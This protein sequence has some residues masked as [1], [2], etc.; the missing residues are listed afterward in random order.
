MK[1]ETKIV[2]WAIGFLAV[3]IWGV[4]WYWYQDIAKPLMKEKQE[5]LQKQEQLPDE[6]INLAGAMVISD[7]KNALLVVYFEPTDLATFKAEVKNK[8]TAF[9][10]LKQGV[11]S[12]TLEFKSKTYK[13][14]GVMVEQI[15]EKKNGDDGKYWMYYVNG[16]IAPVAADKQELKAGDRVEWKF[17]KPKF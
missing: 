17:E 3:I 14:M 2:L 6:S 10:L 5:A 15:G 11:D 4:F 7:P 8:M 16:Q 1:K 9:D 13:G 12:L